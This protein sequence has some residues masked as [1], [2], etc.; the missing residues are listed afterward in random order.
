MVRKFTGCQYWQQLKAFRVG[1]KYMKFKKIHTLVNDAQS[2]VADFCNSAQKFSEGGRKGNGNG[3][4]EVA[5]GRN[6]ILRK[7][8]SCKF[9]FVVLF[10][11]VSLYFPFNFSLLASLLLPLA[12][13]WVGKVSWSSVKMYKVRY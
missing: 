2:S 8:E 12:F 13:A 5:K 11:D 3:E 1:Q 7:N 6:C 10:L 4:S 9:A